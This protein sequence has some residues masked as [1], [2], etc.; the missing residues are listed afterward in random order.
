[1]TSQIDMLNWL[2]THAPA[3]RASDPQTSHDAAEEHPV[4]RRKDRVAVLLAHY[5]NAARGLSDFELADI[6]GRQQTSAGKRR[7]ELRDLGL[8]EA[9][10][11]RRA[12]PSGSTAVVW[13]I[14][15]EGRRFAS[16]IA[17]ERKAS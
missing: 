8:I 11:E 4:L 13:R 12:S 1:M 2:A 14:T 15:A 7:G 5:H 16:E 17:Q 3:A 10:E 6:V 9:T